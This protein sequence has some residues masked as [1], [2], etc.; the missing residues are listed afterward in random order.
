MRDRL[1]SALGG[2]RQDLRHPPSFLTA[3]P[4]SSHGPVGCEQ[5][6]IDRSSARRS[7]VYNASTMDI[8]RRFITLFCCVS[9]VAF[10]IPTP[11]Q[12]APVR[13]LA[14]WSTNALSL[15][16]TYVQGSGRA[17]HVALRMLWHEKKITRDQ[18]WTLLIGPQIAGFLYR[19]WFEWKTARRTEWVRRQLL[20]LLRER[21]FF[22]MEIHAMD[23]DAEERKAMLSAMRDFE[24]YLER[25][26]LR[27]DG[28]AWF[29]YDPLRDA[30]HISPDDADQ[31]QLVL[32]GDF[33]LVDA[34]LRRARWR[35]EPSLRRD[36]PAQA[37]RLMWR[38]R[39]A[40]LNRLRGFL[41]MREGFSRVSARTSAE[42][43]AGLFGPLLTG[44][45]RVTPAVAQAVAA[46]VALVKGV[47]RNGEQVQLYWAF[48]QMRHDPV[49]APLILRLG[50]ALR[51]ESFSLAALDE[52]DA[53]NRFAS[54][55][56]T[57]L[58]KDAASRP[59][60]SQQLRMEAR[61]AIAGGLLALAGSGGLNEAWQSALPFVLLSAAA[62]GAL[63]MAVSLPWL[64]A[65]PRVA[66]HRPWWH[67]P[68][69]EW[70]AQ[71]EGASPAAAPKAEDDLLDALTRNDAVRVRTAIAELS[72]ALAPSGS[73]LSID[74]LPSE[75]QRRLLRL[76]ADG[77]LDEERMALQR[78]F[79]DWPLDADGARTVE[80]A[81]LKS[82]GLW[83]ILP[84][85]VFPA[86]F[87]AGGIPVETIREWQWIMLALTSVGW[88]S[89]GGRLQYWRAGG[90]VDT[91]YDAGPASLA[92]RSLFV[93]S[94]S[95]GRIGFALVPF[96]QFGLL[97][98][99]SFVALTLYS[100]LSAHFSLTP[101]FPG[102]LPPIRWLHQS[103]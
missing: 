23:V 93:A 15:R 21:N 91:R 103:A 66:A 8:A 95:V 42:D 54:D 63:W 11:A 71:A 1:Y 39:I 74:Q 57:Q 96:S 16:P 51:G 26:T 19:I 87:N 45:P 56:W 70:P 18:F 88:G 101:L 77:A 36:D 46:H 94:L 28:N 59:L 37:L 78:I 80:A 44:D 43:I 84:L 6:L 68:T 62:A 75:S 102:F 3:P 100:G 61:P 90:H 83:T 9:L 33:M 79:V 97:A 98:F 47:R 53:R 25:A 34:A 48:D 55:L 29:A 82:W 89:S 30:I 67:K 32:R 22:S 38:E 20:D 40:T 86:A 35:K 13:P 99:V 64:R 31:K 14:L 27:T 65:K 17:A 41:Q 81:T 52:P 73:N 69:N 49:A 12:A 58:Q 7:L 72:D 92:Q 4:S 76:H 85:M 2:L 50:K 10:H 5:G 24:A 60:R